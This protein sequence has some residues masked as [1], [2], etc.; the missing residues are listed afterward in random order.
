VVRIREA[1]DKTTTETACYLLSK[2]LSAD[3]FNEVVRH[4]WSVENRLHWRLD[5]IM[6]KIRTGP[7]WATDRTTWRFFATWR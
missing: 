4:H 5:V 6:K 3:R 2:T 1:P 7:D